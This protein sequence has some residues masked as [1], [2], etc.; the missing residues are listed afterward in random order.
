MSRRLLAL[1]TAALATVAGTGCADDVAPAAQVG[2]VRITESELLDEV[3][4]WA[5]NPAL[6][7][8]VQFPTEM[9]RGGGSGEVSSY[10]TAL[11]DFVLGS[12]VGF[13]VHRAELERRGLEVPEEV[14]DEVEADLFGPQTEAIR[15]E[16]SVEYFDRLVDDVSI[17]ISLQEELG[18]GG[19]DEW[20]AGATED[21]D[22]NPRYGTWDAESAQIIPPDDPA[23]P[24]TARTQ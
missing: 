9:V 5:E 17:R 11:V 10:S 15:E 24:A 21:V 18:E 4:Q 20:L 12:R 1:A 23:A 13:E 6:L 19:Y 7:S 2:D 16:M 8:V 14:R 22:V 3:S